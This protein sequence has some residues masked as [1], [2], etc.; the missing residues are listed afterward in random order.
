MKSTDFLTFFPGKGLYY[1]P[2]GKEIISVYKT[3]EVREI[4]AAVSYFA[5]HKKFPEGLRT[6]ILEKARVL[7][8]FYEQKNIDLVSTTRS[9][10]DSLI[11]SF[12]NVQHS[13]TRSSANQKD[14]DWN[15]AENA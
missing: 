15:I 5:L 2:A 7:K 10:A 3:E 6:D 13:G 8:E 12:D 11:L 4:F 9:P 14:I 1:L